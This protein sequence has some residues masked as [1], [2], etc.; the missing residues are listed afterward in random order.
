VYEK[1]IDEAQGSHT[2]VFYATGLRAGTYYMQFH[3]GT[4]V[5]TKKFVVLQ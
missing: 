5:E 4:I 3:S 2:E 1:Q